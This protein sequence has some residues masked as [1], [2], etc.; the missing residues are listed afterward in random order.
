[1]LAT[2]GRVDEI[3]R[4]MDSLAAQTCVDFELIFADQNADERVLPFVQRAQ[5][6]GWRVQHLRLPE[7]NLSAARNAG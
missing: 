4:L 6:A 2:Y 3:G 7:P 1:V 5:A